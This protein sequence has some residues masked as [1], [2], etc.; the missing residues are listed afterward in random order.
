LLIG[1]SALKYD[2][3][4]NAIADVFE[5]VGKE[6]RDF[7]PHEVASLV[8]AADGTRFA[9]AMLR[10]VNLS[11]EQ[12]L[13]AV[14]AVALDM[15]NA[16][17]D[18]RTAPEVATTTVETRA[19][20]EAEQRSVIAANPVGLPGTRSEVRAGDLLAAEVRALTGASGMGAVFTPAENA[21]FA[22]DFLRKRSVI[23][24]SGV[25]VIRTTGDSIVIPHMLSDGSAG[26][27]A[28]RVFDMGVSRVSCRCGVAVVGR[29]CR[30]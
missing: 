28:E 15:K 25:N 6:K 17:A 16:D 27:I 5:I 21:T 23:F 14:T 19:A 2:Q 11:G 26:A 29:V 18:E 8:D 12:R 20:V 4:V 1:E 10:A 30:G 13:Q 9:S 22:L 7:R 24:R 3:R